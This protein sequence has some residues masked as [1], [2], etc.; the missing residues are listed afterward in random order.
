MSDMTSRTWARVQEIVER[1]LELD[2]A[3]RDAYVENACG[4]HDDAKRRVRLML[5]AADDEDFLGIP[6][7]IRNDNDQPITIPGYELT[8]QLG[9]GGMGVVFRA[10]RVAG[11]MRRPVAIKVL[12]RGMDTDRFVQRFRMERRM[13]AELDH[14][15]IVAAID[16][17]AASDGRPY[18]VMELIDDG[19]PIDEY[20][21]RE[22]LTIDDRVRLFIK[23]CNAVAYAHRHLVVHRDLK[24][25]NILVTPGGE[26]KLL[27]FGVAKV[28]D[29][30]QRP[31]VTTSGERLLTPRYA[32]PE[33]IKGEPVT[34]ETDVYA[35]GVVLYELLTGRSPYDLDTSA[36]SSSRI[37]IA[38]CETDPVR[39]SSAS[40]REP[41][42]S[43]DAMRQGKPAV[44]GDLDVI[45]MK[46][47]EKDPNRR[48][49]GARAL[50]DDLARYL[51]AEPIA[52]RPPSARYRLTTFARRHRSRLIGAGV[53]A[54][55]VTLVTLILVMALVIMPRQSARALRDAHATL[56]GPESQAAIYDAVFF[57]P[58]ID[59][60]LEE[61]ASAVGRHAAAMARA[62]AQ[63]DRALRW[64]PLDVA[65]RR[66]RDIVRR[67]G[68]LRRLGP[69]AAIPQ[70]FLDEFDPDVARLL[71]APELQAA[72]DD[73]PDQA[74]RE[75]GLLLFLA[76]PGQR[77]LQLL[78]AYEARVDPDLLVEGLLG[79]MYLASGH[80]GLAYPRLR[81]AYEAYPNSRTQALA[82]AEAAIEL[83]DHVRAA[84]L[85]DRADALPGADPFDRLARIRARA[86]AAAG[87]SEEAR[88]AFQH[89]VRPI[90][91]EGTGGTS[92]PVALTAFARFLESENDVEAA[93]RNYALAVAISDA[94]ATCES[95]V[96][97]MNSTIESWEPDERRAWLAQAFDPA[98]EL[99]VRQNSDGSRIMIPLGPRELL[100]LCLHARRELSRCMPPVLVTPAD[101]QDYQRRR[102]QWME[103]TATSRLANLLRVENDEAWLHFRAA[104][105]DDQEAL[106]DAWINEDDAAV[107]EIVTRLLQ[108][109]H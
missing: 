27:D 75:A 91:A 18:L 28:L 31:M 1:A 62:E 32:S 22:E 80:H 101:V 74:L 99:A 40:R 56:L 14:P 66:E 23:A 3:E 37:E 72:I 76:R 11:E 95:L 16:G 47:L 87:R 64:A 30:D 77:G 107:T 42:A 70:S 36:S 38:V 6:A 90:F 65:L 67:V 57:R 69:D 12:R 29:P 68:T 81:A 92:N 20:C 88:V 5:A 33:Q 55:A 51:A 58:R 52:A 97:L 7:L 44:A 73:A 103:P 100:Q 85:L 79:E 78:R 43:T 19:V 48:Y 49:D 39:P 96:R 10:E 109:S 8:E 34:T 82:L 9:A 104:H 35:L 15:N 61:R 98:H 50:S 105:K 86:L 83:G 102:R 60:P 21:R 2:G 84:R 63:Y 53:G 54:A 71:D 45:T 46:A 26:P 89:A 59:V 13:L 17:G 108:S 106:L 41:E 94:A 24:P 4:D 25:G 93:L